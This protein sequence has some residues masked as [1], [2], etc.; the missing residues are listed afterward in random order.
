MSAHISAWRPVL[1]VGLIEPY[2]QLF[3]CAAN[4]AGS[5]LD[6]CAKLALPSRRYMNVTNCFVRSFRLRPNYT[7]P[8]NFGE[9]F[10]RCD[11]RLAQGRE[12]YRVGNAQSYGTARIQILPRSMLGTNTLTIREMHQCR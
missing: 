3:R 4:L 6:Q 10:L 9:P 7:L 1:H 11:V 5:C 2:A 12:E 8:R